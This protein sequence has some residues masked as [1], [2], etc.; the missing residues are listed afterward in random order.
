MFH[1]TEEYEWPWMSGP[2]VQIVDICSTHLIANCAKSI[3]RGYKAVP[4]AEESDLPAMA[5][6][7]LLLR[8]VAIGYAIDRVTRQASREN[9]DRYS[10]RIKDSRP[11][12]RVLKQVMVCAKM[13]KVDG[14]AS[15]QPQE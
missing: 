13:D 1:V 15:E 8:G 4:C 9:V 6:R 3:A 5:G 11:L 2:E 10:L 12:C 14:Y 7:E